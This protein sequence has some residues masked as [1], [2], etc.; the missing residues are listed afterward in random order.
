[1]SNYSNS[2]GKKENEFQKSLGNNEKTNKSSIFSVIF[3]FTLI[4]IFVLLIFAYFASDP[5]RWVVTG[6]DHFYMEMIAV[7]LSF[8]VA[9]YL[10]AR[11]YA[12]RDKLSLFLGLGFHVAGIIDLL[13]GIFAIMNLGE[14]AFEGY[15][16]PQTWVA[17]RIV[18]GIIMMIAIAKFSSF[19]KKD[20]LDT[21]RSLSKTVA[22]YTISLTAL[23][24]GITALS[25]IQ[26]F[27][28]VII[29]FIIKRPY[30][31]VSASFY[32][33]AL[34]FFYKNKMYQISDKFYKGIVLVLMIDIFANIIISYSTFVFDNPFNIAHALKN[35]SYF[36]LIIAISSSVIDRYKQQKIMTEQLGESTKIIN[37]QLKKL[38][39]VDKQ[40]EEFA[41]MVTHELKS[42]LTPIMGY[43]EMLKDASFGPLTQDQIG[44]VAKIES[45]TLTLERLISDVLD[46]QRLEMGKMKFNKEN[47][48]VDKLL[49]KLKQDFLPIMKDKGIEFVVVDIQNL[50]ITSDEFRLRQV[51]N[52][53]IR[54]SI[55]FVPLKNARIEIGAKKENGKII[56]HVKDNGSGIPKDKQKN[57]FKKFYQ[58]DTSATRRHS[59]AGL[60]LVISQ[61]MI[62]GLGGEMWFESEPG[63][64]TI[65]HFT[66]LTA[67]KNDNGEVT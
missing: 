25:L 17:G 44:Y 12:L 19:Q 27:P 20:D 32:I 43:C 46:V 53:L 11:G 55:D 67:E 7:I 65:F 24:V 66:V 52:N 56:F 47:F 1:M 63:K 51:F 9:Y 10:I 31:I 50:S 13:H 26:P 29:D 5:N 54:N 22:I 48:D 40:K 23:G 33:I 60:G 18:M 41:S 36:V 3:K 6:I 42:P 2:S 16:I 8:I 39:T 49:C 4:P 35:V 57:I 14:S 38:E 59:G 58:V 62:N 34:F 45:N 30:E 37:V 61:G 21:T 28:F 64:E 15:F